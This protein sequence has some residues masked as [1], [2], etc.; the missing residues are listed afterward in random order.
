MQRDLTLSRVLDVLDPFVHPRVTTRRCR[1]A[2]KDW[3]E[4]DKLTIEV[5]AGD[6]LRL[7]VLAGTL[8]ATT[9]RDYPLNARPSI[10]FVTEL[11]EL[12]EAVR[13]A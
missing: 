12:Q 6:W 9:L 3:P 1:P 10:E 4:F 13:R 5:D 2:P 8:D 7:C 11:E